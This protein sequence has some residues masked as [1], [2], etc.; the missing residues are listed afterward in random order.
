[1]TQIKAKNAS[2][3]KD[4]LTQKIIGCAYKVHSALGPGFNE[5]VYHNAFKLALEGGRISFETEKGFGVQF[6]GRRVGGLRVDLIVEE[7][8]IVEVKAV[9]GNIPKVFESQLLSY[10]RVSGCRVG[11]IVNFGNDR[12]QVKRLVN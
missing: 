4:P 8:V 11:L 12:C 10:L 3:E 2:A 9:T 7:K 6:E 5:C 1:M